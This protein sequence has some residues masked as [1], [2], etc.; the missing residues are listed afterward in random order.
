M[1]GGDWQFHHVSGNITKQFQ[2]MLLLMTCTSYVS[3]YH[4][5][6]QS[7]LLTTQRFESRYDGLFSCTMRHQR[8]LT[9]ISSSGSEDDFYSDFFEDMEDLDQEGTRSGASDGSDDEKENVFFDGYDDFI[10]SLQQDEGSDARRPS[11]RKDGSVISERRSGQRNSRNQ[12]S[13][14]FYKDRSFK[15]YRRDENDDHNNN[16]DE[17]KVKELITKRS[18]AQKERNYDLADSIKEELKSQYGVWVWD[19]DSLWTTTPIAPQR[20]LRDQNNWRGRGRGRGRG[21]SWRQGRWSGRGRMGGR[22]RGNGQGSTA[23]RFGYG[24]RSSTVNRFGR[25]GHDYTQIGDDIS[26]SCPLSLGEIHRLLSQRTMHRLERNFEAADKIGKQLFSNGVRFHDKLRQWRADGA[27]F[28]DVEGEYSGKP[29]TMNEYSEPIDDWDTETRDRLN[30]IIQDRMEAR[31]SR[32]YSKADRLRDM[33]WD[34]YRVAVDDKSRTWSRGG[35][36]GPN[37]TFQWTDD[38]PINPRRGRDPSTI[39]DWRRVGMYELSP[40]S[41]PLDDESEEEEVWNLVHD[42][43]EAKRVQ[44]YDVADT[45]LEH[46]Y[47]H[48]RIS[49]DDRLRQFSIGGNFGELESISQLAKSPTSPDGKVSSSYVQKYNRRGGLGHLTEKD[50]QIVEALIQQRSHEMSRYNRLAAIA[51]R[52]GLKKKYNVIVSDD[53]GE[54]YVRGGDF[55]LSPLMN[56]QLPPFIERSRRDIEDLINKRVQAKLARNFKEVSFIRSQLME[57]Y[58][59]ELDDKLREWIVKIDLVPSVEVNKTVDPKSML[60]VEGSCLK[61]TESTENTGTNEERIVMD[62]EYF[63]SLTVVQLK[64]KAR[65]SGIPV[66]GRKAVLVQRLLD[67]EQQCDSDEIQDQR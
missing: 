28:E 67:H 15:G 2:F 34:T 22:G 17:G 66:S 24:Q 26:P 63:S 43:L 48:Y 38:G 9:Q 54:W 55:V 60:E 58:G 51:I 32:F 44:D 59:V 21:D 16:V 18:V 20:R 37:G 65:A 39:K 40:Y 11:N 6:S 56:D 64:E 12:A 61:E 4:S 25:N 29:F 53:N 31:G 19:R 35:D 5:I 45:I 50:G 10:Q 30:A 57:L 49:V 33:L 13:R 36:F 3:S 47:Q 23:N 1:R 27:I 62:E 41:E 52:K 14:S 7:S 42:R 8:R 46:L